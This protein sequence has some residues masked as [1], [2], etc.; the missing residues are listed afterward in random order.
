MSQND[1]TLANQSF[2]AFRADLNSAL[3]ALASNNSGTSAP[4]TTFANMWWYDSANNIL[5]IRNEDNDA[6]IQF[7]VLDQ[8]TD[9]FKFNNLEVDGNLNIDGGTI[10]L[11]GN[12]PT[13]TDNVALGN[14]VFNGSLTGGYN[15]AMGATAMTALT[16]GSLNVGIGRVALGSLTSGSYNTG[17]GANALNANTT[18]SNNTA[19]GYNALTANTGDNMT[20]VGQNAGLSH[21][22]GNSSTFIGTDSGKLTTTGVG[23]TFVGDGSG[24]QNTT[25]ASNV[26]MGQSALLS[27]TTASNNTAIGYQAG[28]STTTGTQN[29]YLGVYAGYATQVGVRSTYVGYSAGPNSGNTPLA[30]SD[31]ISMGVES[32]WG[33][34]SGS[35][36]T[37]LGNYALRNNNTAS[38]NTAV[39]YSSLGSNTIG[40]NNVSVGYQTLSANTEGTKNTG[41]G[42]QALSANITGSGNVGVGY[43]TLDANTT[44]AN[45]TAIGREA[46]TANTTATDCV[47]V[48]YASGANNTTGNSNTFVGRISGYSTYGA[49]NTLIG[50]QAG[51]F[52]SSGAKN[53]II[54]RYNGNQGGLDI[55]TSSNYIVLSDGDGN[56]RQITTNSGTSS[57]TRDLSDSDR[58]NHSNYHAI[59]NN[60]NTHPALVVEHSGDS[61]P[62]GIFIDLSDADP[63][64]N[65]QWFIKAEGSTG[66]ERFKVSSDGDV[67]NHDNSYG[68][69]SDIKLKEQITDASSQWDDIKALTV[70]KYK[71]KSDVA[72]K[73]DSDAHW[74]LGLIAQEV[75][76]AG[77]NGLVKTNPDLTEN[78]DGEVVDSGT[79]TKSIKYSILYMKAVKALQEA[80]TRIETLE[81]KVTALEGE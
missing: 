72:Q 26:A 27:N 2:P 21:T 18:A 50:E 11:D 75:E 62:N 79:T 29:T 78:E 70:R 17:V 36:N 32:L 14:S 74:R 49:S 42:R 76:T 51:Y 20:A 40:G 65:S 12:Y 80:M 23:N 71:M 39:G 77:M 19:I 81:A 58:A 45:N 13:G 5:Y 4:S 60:L 9:T 57:W 6:W 47:A 38:E 68:A 63:D 54:G 8:T 44:G 7:A 33:I 48:G 41:I 55:R 56:T 25:G 22:T 10:K 1:F 15:T 64:N 52:I 69:I 24:R 66:A 3:Q 43:N 37:A 46:L 34:T 28:Y 59:H 35:Y 31:N 67:Q 30:N 61:T 16:S 53:T 73:G